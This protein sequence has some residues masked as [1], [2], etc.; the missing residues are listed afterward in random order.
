MVMANLRRAERSGEDGAGAAAAAAG[1]ERLP[2]KG[3]ETA[4][5][6]AAMGASG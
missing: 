5:V 2:D 4:A 6:A 1:T 3:S